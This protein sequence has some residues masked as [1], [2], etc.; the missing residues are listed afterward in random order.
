MLLLLIRL[1]SLFNHKTGMF[2]GCIFGA[3]TPLIANERN[4]VCKKN[5]QVCFP[6]NTQKTNNRIAQLALSNI[7]FGI[8]ETAW[9]W[10]RPQQFFLDKCKIN[11]VEIIEAAKKNQQGVLLVGAHYSFLEVIAPCIS[12][13]TSPLT[14]TFKKMRNRRL[15]D[16]S[17]TK[18]S[19]F[20][21]CVEVSNL[22]TIVKELRGGGFVW[23][24]PDQDSSQEN[25]VFAEFFGTPASTTSNVA[26][27]CNITGALPVFVEARREK[28]NYII[29]F[30]AFPDWFP[31]Q[32]QTE[33]AQALNII[34]QD[35]VKKCPTQYMWIHRRFKTQP[36]QTE[37]S[38]YD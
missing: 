16:L 4:K 31:S 24:C 8:I 35:A 20:G 2:F 37:A 34:I 38:I 3:L 19:R 10:H 33:N 13:I 21:K 23:F 12:P 6:H 5:I 29:S 36:K 1:V 26:R 11:G 30:V 18:R 28:G 17:K 25:S 7:G 9:A 14:I 27:L 32:N 15:N 22:R